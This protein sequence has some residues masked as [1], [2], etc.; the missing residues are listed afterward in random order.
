MMF[1]ENGNSAA[2]MMAVLNN[3]TTASTTPS[4]AINGQH[5]VKFCIK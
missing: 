5:M 4:G 2:A 1:D 3:A